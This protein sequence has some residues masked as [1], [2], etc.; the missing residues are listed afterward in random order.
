MQPE[1]FGIF[2]EQWIHKAALIYILT[3]N[4]ALQILAW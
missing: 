4:E 1:K 3:V 2:Q